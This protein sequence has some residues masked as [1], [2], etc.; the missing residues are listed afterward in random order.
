MVLIR[1]ITN[2][3]RITFRGLVTT[4][5]RGTGRT[6]SAGGALIEQRGPDHRCA[7]SHEP[8]G[9]ASRPASHPE[10]VVAQ[11]IEAQ[12]VGVSKTIYIKSPSG[13]DGSYKLVA[14]FAVGTDPDINTVLV[15]DRS[16]ARLLGFL[17]S[18]F[19]RTPAPEPS[20]H[21]APM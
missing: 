6:C 7:H 11:P 12:V 8:H 5:R 14:T 9:F 4:D 1:S 3:P 20:P 2:P 13:S 16:S 19:E 15:Q 17:R 21:G 10:A 18:P